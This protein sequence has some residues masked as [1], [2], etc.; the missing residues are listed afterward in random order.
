MKKYI[1]PFLLLIL[2]S[3]CFAQSGWYVQN[4][5]TS[6]ELRG[7]FFINSQ[8]GWVFGFLNTIKKTTNGGNNWFYQNGNTS[9]SFLG[10]YFINSQ[11]G[12]LCG[13]HASQSHTQISKT[14][15]GGNNWYTVFYHPS[16]GC[17][18]CIQFINSNTGWVS[19]GSGSIMK[20]T[21][22]GNSWSTI[23]L[24]I[25]NS[26]VSHFF[27]NQNTGWVVGTNGLIK[28]TTNGGLNWIT[29]LSPLSQ[30]LL[31]IHF[32]NPDTGFISGNNG[33]ILKTT[34]SG[35]NWIQKYSPVTTWLNSVFFINSGTGWIVGGEYNGGASSILNTVD[36]GETWSLQISPVLSWLAAVRFV[37]YNTGWACGR[38]GTIIKTISGGVI[39][40]N[41]PVLL[42]PPNGAININT[43]PTLTWNPSLSANS[44]KVII[45]TN[46][47]FSTITD[48][49]TVSTNYYNV[50]SGKLQ[51]GYTY[52]W[53]VN[54]SNI[55]GTSNWSNI[56]NFS[57]GQFP[58]APVLISPL[59]GTLVTTLTPTLIWHSLNNVL[60]YK[61]QISTLS[62]FLIITDSATVTDSHYTVPSGKLFAN[63]TY[64]WRVNATNSF[65]T[66]PWSIVWSFIPYPT[67]IKLLS[68]EIPEAFRLY[69][70]Y[71][72]PFNSQTNI[73][74]DLPE[75]S[76][77]KLTLFDILGRNIQELISMYLNEGAYTYPFNAER[78]NSGIYFIRLETNK[79]NSI[80]RI[81]L[82]K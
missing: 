77:I 1:P 38:D 68:N 41:P 24:N 34:N 48:S 58:N 60:N 7:E 73:R 36:E 22:G 42:S 27:I 19:L 51:Y 10:G 9:E 69:Q 75:K 70:N 12:W 49:A 80:I 53:K 63:I 30:N 17:A 76:Q 43:T 47:N 67:D 15:D 35:T 14:T 11:T 56:W 62:N 52:F 45:S 32:V 13:G 78:L 44:Y 6:E 16:N 64:F 55:Y 40:P 46:S 54:A 8:T 23:S 5:L 57:T 26:L 82:I 39:I 4:Q 29:Q 25:S 79:Y 66:G 3:L 33:T 81:V 50:P 59:N 21:D 2:T 74:F 71:P 37:D 28:K 61:V 31:C 65:G 20:T 18:Y 72:N